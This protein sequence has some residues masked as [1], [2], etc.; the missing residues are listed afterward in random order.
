[1]VPMSDLL[2][3]R[4]ALGARLGDGTFAEVWQATDHAGLG[5]PRLVALKIFRP[6]RN[7]GADTWDPLE[8]EVAVSA[9]LAPHPQVVKAWALLSLPF[10]GVAATPCL[11]L[12]HIAGSNLALW[13]AGQPPPG[14]ATV[15]PRLAVLRGLLGGLAHAHAGGVAHQDISFGNVLVRDGDPPTGVLTDFGCARTEEGHAGAA[16]EEMDALQPINPPPYALGLSLHDGLRRDLYAF[17][18]LAWLVLTARHPLTDDW[19][20]MR[21]GRWQGPASP[22]RSL[23]RRPMAGLAPWIGEVAGLPPLAG[24]LLRCLAAEPGERP[25]SAVEVLLDWD[26]IMGRTPG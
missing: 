21:Q 7:G 23:P 17:A 20:S 19:Q 5:G 13:L 12:D 3:G 11:M 2:A 6:V 14:V 8:R 22:H 1:M 10:F 25:A 15:G 26:A 18:T 24:M 16:D 9:R 4:F